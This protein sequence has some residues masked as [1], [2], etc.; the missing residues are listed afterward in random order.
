VEK[1]ARDQRGIGRNGHAHFRGF[2]FS[3]HKGRDCPVLKDERFSW[4]GGKACLVEKDED[5]GRNKRDRDDRRPLGWVVVMQRDHG[6]LMSR[7]QKKSVSGALA[8]F[9]GTVNREA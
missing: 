1:H 5:A 2:G 4:A 9:P 6:A 3:E 8:S 7:M